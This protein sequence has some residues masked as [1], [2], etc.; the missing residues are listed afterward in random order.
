MTGCRWKGS[1]AEWSKALVL[2]TNLRAWVRIPQLSKITFFF[3]LFV[4]ET[5]SVFVNL[6][7]IFRQDVKAPAG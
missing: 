3:N 2:G 5:L 4:L 1:L 6:A 7:N